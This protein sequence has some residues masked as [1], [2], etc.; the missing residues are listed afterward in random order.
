MGQDGNEG[1]KLQDYTSGNE[2]GGDMAIREFAAS[3]KY[4][5]FGTLG[6]HS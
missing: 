5:S 6:I 4:F 3:K 1:T 2:W